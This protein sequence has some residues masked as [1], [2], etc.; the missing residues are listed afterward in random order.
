M[1]QYTTVT[2]KT[3]ELELGEKINDLIQQ[4]QLKYNIYQESTSYKISLTPNNTTIDLNTFIYNN[5]ATQFCIITEDD[6]KSL[7]SLLYNEEGNLVNYN[8]L[9]YIMGIDGHFKFEANNLDTN[10]LKNIYKK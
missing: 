5:I 7:I 8:D 9:Y 10:R 4:N 3:V 1:T 2:F 6:Y